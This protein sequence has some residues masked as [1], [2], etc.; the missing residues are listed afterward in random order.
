MFSYN[1]TDSNGSDDW[2]KLSSG[3]KSPKKGGK[4]VKNQSLSSLRKDVSILYLFC[5]MTIGKNPKQQLW[6]PV[7]YIFFLLDQLDTVCSD[8]ED[9]VIITTN[10][11]KKK[12][13]HSQQDLRRKNYFL[14]FLSTLLLM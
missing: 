5:R 2:E 3:E 14:S 8:Q 6:Y 11:T 1:S 12:T 7:Y 4:E 13:F 9:G 10:E